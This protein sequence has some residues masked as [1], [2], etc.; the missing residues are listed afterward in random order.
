[1]SKKDE[2]EIQPAEE[3]RK[4][5]PFVLAI[6]RNKDVVELGSILQAMGLNGPRIPADE[7]RDRSFVLLGCKAFQSSFQRDAHAYFCVCSDADTGEV[8]TTVLGGQACVD[9]IDALVAQE[10][11]APLKVTLRWSEGGAFQGY[12]TLE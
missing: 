7:L 11:D 10:F 1:M 9:V 2:T 6:D 4:L 5:N 3:P 8:F 12:Y